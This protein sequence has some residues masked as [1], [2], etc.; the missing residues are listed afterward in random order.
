MK[1]K[2]FR[3]ALLPNLNFSTKKTHAIF[4]L[5][6]H[7][8]QGRYPTSGFSK[9]ILSRPPVTARSCVLS[10]FFRKD[11]S[12]DTGSAIRKIERPGIDSFLPAGE[13]FV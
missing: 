1:S 11:L 8:N 7:A 3:Y 10:G 6:V 12:A 5:S 2:R 4:T 9:K 13:I